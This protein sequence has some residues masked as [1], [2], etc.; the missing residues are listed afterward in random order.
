M[1]CKGFV[2]LE[3]DGPGGDGDD[4]TGDPGLPGEAEA[5]PQGGK[6]VGA[7]GGK[8]HPPEPAPEGKAVDPSHL[9]K[10]PVCGGNALAHVLP[11]QG[12]DH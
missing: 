10:L 12:E 6:K 11:G 7:H 2:K 1:R 8:V 4:L 3:A 5:H 9:Q